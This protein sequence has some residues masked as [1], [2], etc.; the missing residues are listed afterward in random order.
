MPTVR[1]ENGGTAHDPA[2]ASKSLNEKIRW[3]TK[4]GDNTA[5]TIT[6]VKSPFT[7]PGPYHSVK[8]AS[9]QEADSGAIREDI[10]DDSTTQH[11]YTITQ[12]TA[13]ADPNVIIDP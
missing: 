7:P 6:F 11:K 8:K 4:P 9:Y 2:R 10:P 3:Q 1:I 12:R 13:G 5:F